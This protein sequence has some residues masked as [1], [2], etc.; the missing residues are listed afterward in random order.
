MVK[1]IIFDFDGVL[2]DSVDIKKKAFAK[3]FEDESP[4]VIKA[5][6]EHH[7]ANRS[8]SR[9]EKI[10]H[11]Y[12]EFLKQPLTDE[13]LNSLCSRFSGLV[14]EEIIKAPYIEGAK[15]FLDNYTKTY[16]CYVVSSTPEDELRQIVN[17]R[18][19]SS[20]FCVVYGAPRAKTDII[21]DILN[22]TNYRPEEAVFIGDDLLDYKAAEING[23]KFIAVV[24][25]EDN[26]LCSL[27]DITKVPNLSSLREILGVI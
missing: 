7:L 18:N 4:E 22:T 23:I 1:I 5:I 25:D 3:L 13:M 6:V 12:K 11:Y 27:D 24:C 2:V 17:E 10:S 26:L 21:K 19:M 8:M 16:K 14:V 15:D 9:F 20:Y